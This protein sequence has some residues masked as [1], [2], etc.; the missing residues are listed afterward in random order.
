MTKATI[1]ALE[2][3]AAYRLNITSPCKFMPQTSRAGMKAAM[4]SV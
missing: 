3:P 1:R 2:M 4:T